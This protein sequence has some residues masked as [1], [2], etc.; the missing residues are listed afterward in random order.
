MKIS[1]I[2]VYNNKNVLEKCLLESLKKQNENY[3]L[4][5]VDNRSG[6]F[7]SAADALNWG[8]NKSTG[9]LLIFVH[10]DVHFYEDN[11]TDIIKYCENSNNLGI[12]GVAGMDP[13][14]GVMKSNGT[15]YIPPQ[16]MSKNH[17]EHVENAQTLDE[18]LLIIP[19]NIF[20]NY[21]FDSE[22]CHDWHLYGVDYCLNLLKNNYNVLVLP[23]EL[24][25]E[26]NGGSMSP[27]YYKTLKKILKK[28]KQDFTYIHTS[29]AGTFNPNKLIKVNILYYLTKYPTIESVAMIL[30]K[31]KLLKKFIK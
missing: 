15:H 19:R 25:H 17:I 26:S 13:L 27:E 16:D 28:Y 8:G 24:Y 5:L 4:I 3:E 6:K 20:K 11:L 10:Q 9:D 14:T 22:V 31:S 30:G 23:I 1:I 2:S 29:C 7:K 21:K 12:A 18:V